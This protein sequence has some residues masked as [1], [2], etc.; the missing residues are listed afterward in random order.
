MI[1]IKSFEQLLGLLSEQ[2]K[3]S[4][5]DYAMFLADQEDVLTSDEVELVK[6][7]REEYEKGIYFSHEEA[8]K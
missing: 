6:Q 1:T 5:F 4:L 8:W 2:K 7:N 3:Q